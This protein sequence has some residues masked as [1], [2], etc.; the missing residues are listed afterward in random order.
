MLDMHDDRISGR[1]DM[2]LLLIL[3]L[4]LCTA[5]AMEL[6]VAGHVTGN[7]TNETIIEIG[8]GNWTGNGTAWVLEW[9]DENGSYQRPPL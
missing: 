9:S 3:F 2:R 1:G 7:G 4:L 5:S 6:Y 8:E